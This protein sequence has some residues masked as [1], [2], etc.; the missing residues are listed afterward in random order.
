[1]GYYHHAHEYY[2]AAPRLPYT[3]EDVRV[4]QGSEDPNC[5]A[6]TGFNVLQAITAH[7][8]YF[9]RLGY[10]LPAGWLVHQGVRQESEL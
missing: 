8:D 1:M 6:G 10:C 9:H 5:I 3:A 2:I 7:Q 4:C